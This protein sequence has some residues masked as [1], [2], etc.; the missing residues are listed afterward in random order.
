[1]TRGLALLIYG[2]EGIG[3]TGTALQFAHLGPLTCISA[4]ETGYEYL[5]IIN[6]VPSNCT[7]YVVESYEEIHSITKK[8]KEGVLVLD[9]LSGLQNML[10]DYVCRIVYNGKRDDFNNYWKG[11]RQDSPVFFDQYLNL[12]NSLCAKGIHVILLGHCITAEVLNALGPDYVSHMLDMDYSDKGASLR[13][14]ATKWAQAILFMDIDIAITRVT[15][16]AKDK[17]VLEGKAKDDDNRLIYTTKSANHSAKNK[18]QLPPII[19]M[20]SSAQEAF[21]NLWSHMPKAYQDLL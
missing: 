3:K 10:F 7:N 19:P 18:L 9:S 12:L 17:T 2:G 4:G 1:M 16:R 13:S 21:R 11:Q 8:M 14:C 20:G 6:E 15:E 5:D